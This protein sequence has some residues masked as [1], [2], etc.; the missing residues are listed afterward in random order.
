MDSCGVDGTYHVN[1]THSDGRSCDA[2]L[3][4]IDAASCT[5]SSTMTLT[6][7]QCRSRRSL[8]GQFRLRYDMRSSADVRQLNLQHGTENKKNRVHNPNGISIGS[9]VFAQLTAEYRRRF[10]GM[11]I[12]LKIALTHGRS[13]PP[14]NTR[15]LGSTLCSYWLP[16]SKNCPFP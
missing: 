4:D 8:L 5:S 3:S 9:S 6:L 13:E 15:F 10:R 12:S 2:T 16:S 7:H 11:P 1:V 14:S